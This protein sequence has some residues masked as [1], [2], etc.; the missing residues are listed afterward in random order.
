MHM[1][2]SCLESFL[3]ALMKCK[4]AMLH[5]VRFSTST[6]ASLRHFIKQYVCIHKLY[7]NY[8]STSF[9]TI[10][11]WSSTPLNHHTSC[12]ENT[13]QIFL[14]NSSNSIHTSTKIYQHNPPFS[15]WKFL[16]KSTLNSFINS[17]TH[18]KHKNPSINHI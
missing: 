3:C 2:G 12:K 18:F 14:S 6:H 11:N 15:W 16:H 10:Q 5:K 17:S 13:L 1:D 7:S 4:Y 9:L 8:N